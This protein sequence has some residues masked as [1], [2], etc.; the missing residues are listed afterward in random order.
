MEILICDQDIFIMLYTGN[1]KGYTFKFRNCFQ[2][3][4]CNVSAKG[5]Y[6]FREKFA[7]NYKNLNYIKFHY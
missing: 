7:K 4:S 2:R 3:N 1:E 6:F 5:I